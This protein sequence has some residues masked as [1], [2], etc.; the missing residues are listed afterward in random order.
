MNKKKSNK[1]KLHW[2]GIKKEMAQ[3]NK[4]RYFYINLWFF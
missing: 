3:I 2:N 4:H 1:K